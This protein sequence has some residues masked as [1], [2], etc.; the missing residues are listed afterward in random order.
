VA[1]EEQ[2]RSWQDALAGRTRN[3]FGTEIADIMAL[4][5]RTDIISFC[6]G[7]PDPQTF[8]GSELVEVLGGL[9]D[10][11]DSAAF[12]YAPTPGLPSTRD[13][14]ADRIETLHGRRPEDGELLVTSGGIEAL[15]LL[16]KVLV[17]P[18]DAVVVEAPTYLG[19][20]MGL[21]GHG[22]HVVALP[23]DSDGLRVDEVARELAGGLRPKLLYAISDFQNPTGLTLSAERRAALVELARRYGFLVVEDVAYRE[24]RFG[25]REQPPSLWSLG[26]DVV[27][28]ISTFS[29]TFCPGVR[30]GW[31][32]GPAEIVF[33]LVRAKQNTDQC[34]AALG[35]RLLEEWGRRGH[36]DRRIAASRDLY[37]QRCR[38]TLEAL[39]Q[40]MPAGVSWTEPEGGFFTWVTL[41]AGIDSVELGRRA[42]DEGVA[43]VPGVPFFPP[44]GRGHDGL[45]LAYS[46]VGDDEIVEGCGRLARLVR[47][48]MP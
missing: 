31:A 9:V 38:L 6:G 17:D 37:G 36:L 19:A 32:V 34:A 40:A 25:A 27:C 4:A 12:Q 47:E 18:G 28:Q 2:V 15:D 35:Q 45:R 46:R 44:D 23:L 21:A 39:R 16:G 5:N 3:G 48:A 41:P 24:L 22:A 14:L 29:K 13:Y 43:F 26:P 11:G 20:V 33:E 1:V 8:P 10:S 30:L 7:I 42:M